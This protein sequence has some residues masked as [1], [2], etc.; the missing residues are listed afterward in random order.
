MSALPSTLRSLLESTVKK[1]RDLAEVGAR[2][3]LIALGVEAATAPLHLSPSQKQLRTRLRAHGKQVGD[4][5]Q[6]NGT[7]TLTHLVWDTAYEQW[8]QML[9]ARFL[10]ENSLLMHPSGVAVTLADCAELVE[11]P[12]EARGATTAAQLAAIFATAML[13]QIFRPHDPVLAVAFAPEHQKPLEQLVE[14]LPAAVFTAEDSLGWVYQFW[15]AKRKQEVN[16]SEVK[17]GAD[18]LPAVTQL[19][20]EPYMVQFLLH[21]SLG[22][23]WAAKRIPKALWTTATSEDELRTAA[24]EGLHGYAF[25]Y[26]R[27]VRGE[28]GTW[29]PAAGTFPTWPSVAKDLK[30]LDPCCGSGHFLVA[31]LHLLSRFRMIEEDLSPRTAID[32]VLR[33]NLHGLEIDPRCTQI[34]AFAVA[35]A[36]W[37]FPGSEG[38]RSL[39]A[40]HIACSGLRVAA[41]REEWMAIA[42]RVASADRERLRQGM[43]R[44][45]DVFQQAPVLGSLLDPGQVTGNGDLFTAGW[46]ELLPLLQQTISNDSSIEG[47]EH[48][49]FGI[50]ARGLIDAARVMSGRYCFVGT[51]VPY[52]AGGKQVEE[53]RAWIDANSFDARADLATVFLDRSMRFCVEGGSTALVMPQNWHFLTTYRG[54]RERLLAET[55]WNFIARLGPKG[56]IT[57]MWDFNVQLFIASALKAT[58]ASMINGLD[59]SQAKTP[60]EKSLELVKC[61]LLTANQSDQSG[62]PDSIISFSE[63][64]DLP[65][66]SQCG[67]GWQG[68]ATSDSH[69]FCMSYFEIPFIQ[70]GWIPFQGGASPSIHYGG[71]E[72]VIFWEDGHGELTKICQEGASFRG[73]SAWGKRGVTVGQMSGL[74]ATIYTG[75]HFGNSS[76]TIIPISQENITAFWVYCSSQQFADDLRKINQKLSVDNGYIGKIPFDLDHWTTICQER[77]PHGLPKPYTDD[78]TQWIFHG[79]PCGSVI[80]S[81]ATN[82]TD[83]G[84]IRRDT[85]VL[86]IALARLLG[87]RW[88][89]E[90]DEQMDLVD[91]IAKKADRVTF[92][93]KCTEGKFESRRTAARKRDDAGGKEALARCWEL[94]SVAAYVSLTLV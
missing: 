55:T 37:T 16:D 2:A 23:W 94:Q 74:P 63:K 71:R 22:A 43:G 72:Q 39:P 88:P 70:G 87:Y 60:A 34:A 14:A 93:K 68:I 67:N 40:P 20:T 29:A 21:N 47:E 11:D 62:N 26:L 27:C 79:H 30:T 51:K 75:E 10:A 35:L 78:P 53:L 8:H 80:W 38:F 69:R 84:P 90:L 89:A 36:A 56:F 61:S 32:A 50:T 17:I 7:Q 91:W 25:T 12:N 77:Y 46:S 76:P 48:L 19:F 49:E 28:D 4:E 41:K 5:R 45:W 15:Q 59:V 13:P 83:H 58:T 86:S 33:D 92:V 54:L 81:D 57:P 6:T 24:A 52:L 82:R 31:L 44:L 64:S 42:D 66:F 65:L 3:G 85:T 9:F 18:E 73:V 1:A